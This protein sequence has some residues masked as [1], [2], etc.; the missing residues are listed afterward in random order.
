MPAWAWILIIAAIVVV[1]AILASMAIRQ[2]RTTMLRQ[3]FGEEYERTVN[4]RDD[5]RAAEADLRAR[6]RHRAQ[7]EVTPL[8]EP[9]RA[10]FVTEWR[11]AQER[12]VD[13]PSAAVVAADILVY[14]VMGARGYPMESFDAQA[15]L[16]SVDHPDVVENYRAAHGIYQRAQNQQASTEELRAALLHYRTLFDQLLQPEAGDEAEGHVADPAVEHHPRGRSRR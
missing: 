7:F 3:R 4:A 14:R 16:V 10:R 5:Q 6:E 12:F 13:E 1:G 8:P 11:D 15:D 9:D 2:R